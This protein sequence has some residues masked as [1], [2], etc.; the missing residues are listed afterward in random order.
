MVPVDSVRVSRDPTYSGIL[1]GAELCFV[2]GTVTLCGLAFQLL[3]LHYQRPLCRSYNPER[4]TLSVWA[5]PV[6]LAA[7]KGIDFSFFSS[8]YLDVSVHQVRSGISGSKVVC[9]LPQA[10]RRLPRQS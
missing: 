9:H 7:T 3:P 5:V 10:Y 2:Y 4:E 1:L 8:G 6:S